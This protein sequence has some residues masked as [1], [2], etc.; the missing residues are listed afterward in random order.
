MNKEI[1]ILL[2][3]IAQ[4]QAK[5]RSLE[6]QEHQSYLTTDTRF[7]A[8]TVEQHKAQRVPTLT[9]LRHL[10]IPVHVTG[11]LVYAML[12]PTVFLDIC[13][14]IFQSI[15]FRVWKIERVRRND[16]IVIDR[17]HLAYL[18][19]FEKINCVYC[20][21]TNGVYEIAVEIAA[22]TE[23]HWCPIKH[24]KRTKHPHKHYDDFVAY[25]DHENWEE[26]PSRKY[27]PPKDNSKP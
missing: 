19:A 25:G 1:P 9:Y 26:H 6:A 10:P 4:L 21:Y 23:R 13:L 5:V 15:C 27:V 20:G 3:E 17:H 7:D 2:N 8:K 12:V 18:N 24:A 22:R 14:M 11:P 16:H